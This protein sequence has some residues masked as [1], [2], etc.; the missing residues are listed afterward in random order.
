[1]GT[2]WGTGSPSEH[3]AALPCCAVPEHWHRLPRGCGVSSLGMFRSHLAM[4]LGPLLWVSL[5]EQGWAR[6]PWQ[7]QLFCDSV[8]RRK[9]DVRFANKLFTDTIW[10]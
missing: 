6:G 5:L 3:Q 4:G 1:M 2:N 9:K 7:P 8:I 10:M